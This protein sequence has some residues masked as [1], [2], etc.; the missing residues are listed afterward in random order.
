MQGNVGRDLR[1]TIPVTRDP[2][3]PTKQKK[4]KQQRPHFHLVHF[5]RKVEREYTPL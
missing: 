5:L 3:V 2:F 4:K 1:E